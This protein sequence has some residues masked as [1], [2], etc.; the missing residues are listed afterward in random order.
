MSGESFSDTKKKECV[1]TSDIE[2]GTHSFIEDLFVQKA[3][4]SA[5]LSCVW[6][7]EKKGFDIQF[8]RR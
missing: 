2:A 6:Y 3:K 8:M 4:F 1:S 5:F 7:D